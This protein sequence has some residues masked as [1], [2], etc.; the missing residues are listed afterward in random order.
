MKQAVPIFTVLLALLSTAA[1]ATSFT[2]FSVTRQIEYARYVVFGRIGSREVRLAPE[3]GQPYTYW[4]LK[5]QDVYSDEKLSGTIEIRSPGGQIDGKG[6]N[7]A[8]A[9]NFSENEQVVVMLR[10]TSEDAKQIIGLASGKYK[11]T[12]DD[13][14]NEILK[15]GLGMVLKDNSGK[16]INLSGFRDLASRV[17]THDVSPEERKILVNPGALPTGVDKSFESTYQA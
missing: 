14:G 7:V 12:K 11:L 15:S 5:I 16:I 2:S 10:D 3:T 9:A 6:Y 8:G 4:K 13:Q 1:S 17:L